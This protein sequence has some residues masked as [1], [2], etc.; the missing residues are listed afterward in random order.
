MNEELEEIPD[1]ANEVEPLPLA[2]LDGKK[3][4]G[5]PGGRAH[6]LV[7]ANYPFRGKQREFSKYDTYETC[8]SPEGDVLWKRSSNRLPDGIIAR[9]QEE[10]IQRG[11]TLKMLAPRWNLPYD[12]V[13][14]ISIGGRWVAKR[15]IY[16]ARLDIKSTTPAGMPLVAKDFIPPGTPEAQAEK[17]K[18]EYAQYV[19]D[20][21]EMTKLISEQL[22]A[23]I[24]T[25][26]TLSIN[27]LEK[28]ARIAQ[29]MMS[30]Q[31]ILLNL[32]DDKPILK[33]QR[34]RA[35]NSKPEE[36]KPMD[37]SSLAP[38]SGTRGAKPTQIV[39]LSED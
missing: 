14:R 5:D 15:K 39:Q 12:L 8:L 13:K 23:A 36:V 27:R 21:M 33:S 28:A 37:V 11:Y 35:K 22:R 26:D 10:F 32:Q 4:P 1:V 17:F 16:K 18:K 20:G 38:I 31:R 19:Q 3:A 24:A 2:G 6:F 29:D 34:A 9:I 7:A 25:N 30:A